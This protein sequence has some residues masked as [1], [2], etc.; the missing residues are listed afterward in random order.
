[1]NDFYLCDTAM[2][3]I[4][5]YLFALIL[6][7]LVFYG[8]AGINVVSYCCDTCRAAGIEAVSKHTCCEAHEN[9]SEHQTAKGFTCGSCIDQMHD[10]CCGLERI[11]YDWSNQPVSASELNIEPVTVN[12]LFACLSDFSIIPSLFAE[13]NRTNMS[14]GPPLRTPR[15]YLSLLTILLI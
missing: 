7:V 8:G 9:I 11:Q 14:T 15:A 10:M 4:F 12:L 3:K 5:T 2:K 1:M 13:A 6:S